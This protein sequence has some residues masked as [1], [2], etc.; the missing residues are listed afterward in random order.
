MHQFFSEKPGRIVS[1]KV[2][3]TRRKMRTWVEIKKLK[4][5]CYKEVTYMWLEKHILCFYFKKDIATGI[6]PMSCPNASTI[7]AQW[8][9]L[10]VLEK[11]CL[12][13]CCWIHEHF[14]LRIFFEVCFQL[15]FSIQCKHFFKQFPKQRMYLHSIWQKKV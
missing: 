12:K 10:D 2:V 1:F 13:S 5:L 4:H 6:H 8:P 9:Y 3:L 11:K 14:Y 15:P 7:L